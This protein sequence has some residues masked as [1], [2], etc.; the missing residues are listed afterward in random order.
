MTLSI[1]G[2]RHLRWVLE[3]IVRGYAKGLKFISGALIHTTTQFADGNVE[4]QEACAD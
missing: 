3:P 1:Y 4:T 2:F